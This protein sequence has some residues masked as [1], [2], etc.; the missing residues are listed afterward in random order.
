[1]IPP[2]EITSLH[3]HNVDWQEGP[4][5]DKTSGYEVFCNEARMFFNPIF[6]SWFTIWLSFYIMKRRSGFLARAEVPLLE[7]SFQLEGHADYILNPAGHYTSRKG[8]FNLSY[9]PY[10]ES[11]TW[12]DTGLKATTL[13]IHIPVTALQERFSGMYPF[14]DRFI[15]NVES[16]TPAVLFKNPPKVT[17]YMMQLVHCIIRI[18]KQ[19][20]VNRLGLEI[21]VF[22]LL[23]Y[24]FNCRTD[25]ENKGL[26]VPSELIER[27]YLIQHFIET[28]FL[29]KLT[30]PELAKQAHM[31]QVQFKNLFKVVSQLPSLQY[32]NQCRMNKA[33]SDL[34]YTKEPINN[35]ADELGFSA[36][37]NFA[38]AFSEKS[39]HSPRAYRDRFP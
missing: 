5:I 37:G 32:R 10:M 2:F 30:I 6:C 22:C 15:K 11:K 28:S 29:Q 20:T 9:L 39:G 8:Y 25:M 24:G 26:K 3:G 16:G 1:M 27:I 7:F 13:D 14:L 31:G 17:P 4:I 21:Y 38:T 36:P 23:N 35:I 12:F 18:L 19:K 33:S 34:V